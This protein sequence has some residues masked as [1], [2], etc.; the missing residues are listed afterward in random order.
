MF[1][2]G[3]DGQLGR[4]DIVESMAA[5]RA[6]PKEVQNISHNLKSEVLELALG[7]NHSIALARKLKDI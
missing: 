3:R 7:S 2:R 5:F 4:G 1:G 6:E